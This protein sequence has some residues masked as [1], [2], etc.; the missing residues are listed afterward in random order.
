MNPENSES[1]ATN[2]SVS[3][4][5][6]SADFFGTKTPEPVQ[7]EAPVDEGADDT[8]PSDADDTKPVDTTPAPD[9]DS[10]DGD[11]DGEPVVEKKPKKTAAERISEVVAERNA[12]RE[13]A[14][15]LQARIEALEAANAPKKEEVQTPAAAP[16]DD[17]P[18][19]D[20]K[21]E[22]GSLK[23]PLGEYDAQYLA[24]RVDYL[25]AKKEQEAEARRVQADEQNK[26]INERT[27][28]QT[29][30]ETK[31]QEAEKNEDMADI[32]ESAAVLI[33]DLQDK[34]SPE[35]GDYLATTIMQ[36]EQGP[37]V[38]YFL[39]QNP[40]VAEAIASQDAFKAT[41]A[42]GGLNER[43]RYEKL[44]QENGN[45]KPRQSK[46]PEPPRNVNRGA[47]GRFEVPGDTEDLDAFARVFLKK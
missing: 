7:T 43:I 27:Q 12:E 25:F 44:A 24:D 4:D 45:P 14:A 11:G 19:P 28:L 36:L 37:E 16:E 15:A 29:T 6:F 33:S 42:L 35:H 1:N 9:P 23:Y 40:D 47:S 13:R 34:I 20:A 31:L 8:S 5:D 21:N 46:A 17:A 26:I 2:D 10:N 18:D 32:R 39:A 41:I 30:W 22:D 38:L 3:L